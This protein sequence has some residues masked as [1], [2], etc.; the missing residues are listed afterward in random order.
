MV[1]MTV[2]VIMP[3]SIPITVS[4]TISVTLASDSIGNHASDIDAR[5]SQHFCSTENELAAVLRWLNDQCQTVDEASDD[6]SVA[7]GE[8]WRAVD[9]NLIVVIVGQAMSSDI[10]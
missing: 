10:L 1:V 8:N 9:Q 5:S 3:I 2:A 7:G 4:I 6:G